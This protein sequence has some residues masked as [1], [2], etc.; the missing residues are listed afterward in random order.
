MSVSHSTASFLPTTAAEVAARGWE[1][2]DVIFVSGDQKRELNNVV[3]PAAGGAAPA[4][5]L[6]RRGAVPA[7]AGR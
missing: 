1:Q 4:S 2:P 6:R 3:E 5:A 7:D